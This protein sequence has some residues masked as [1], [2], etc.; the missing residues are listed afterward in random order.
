MILLVHADV[1]AEIQKPTSRLR[2][3]G[4]WRFQANIGNEEVTE[5]EKSCAQ[6]QHAE[7]D[8]HRPVH[9]ASSA[10]LGPFITYP[11]HGA[12]QGRNGGSCMF[13]TIGPESLGKH[14]QKHDTVSSLFAGKS[15]RLPRGA[16][17]MAPRFSPT[18]VRIQ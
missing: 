5:D 14:G 13:E 3:N 6:Q 10:I 1:D 11:G 2:G 16:P 18:R 12:I 9:P 17:W 7:N 15:L 4:C 8:R